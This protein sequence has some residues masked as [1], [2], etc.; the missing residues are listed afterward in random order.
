VKW[1]DRIE[2]REV[3]WDGFFQATVYRLLPPE[4]EPAPGAG[5]ALVDVALNAEI[6]APQDGAR[7]AL[8]LQALVVAT[9]TLWGC[10]FHASTWVFAF[11]GV[12]MLSK[13]MRNGYRAVALH[14]IGLVL[15]GWGKFNLIEGV[16]DHHILGIHYVRAGD[17]EL[18]YDLAFLA[19]GA[20]LLVGGLMLARRGQRESDARAGIAT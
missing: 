3:P 19:L 12:M 11:V 10:L 9:N 7:L 14:Q 20:A 17:N 16:V 8:G 6:L 4:G 15:A 2:L 13:A 5:I 1:L 18:A